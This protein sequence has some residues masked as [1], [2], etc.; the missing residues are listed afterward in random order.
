MQVVI[1]Q[2]QTVNLL[3]AWENA[4]VG[5][6]ILQASQFTVIIAANMDIFAKESVSLIK[7]KSLIQDLLLIPC[8]LGYTHTFLRVKKF[9]TI[10]TRDGAL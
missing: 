5:V 2:L 10:G 9:T 7:K 1:Q 3:P 4:K 6:L 8:S